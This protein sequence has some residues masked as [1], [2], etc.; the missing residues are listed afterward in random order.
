MKNTNK[1]GILKYLGLDI[2]FRFQIDRARYEDVWYDEKLRY[3]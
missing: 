2:G 1:G 3:I